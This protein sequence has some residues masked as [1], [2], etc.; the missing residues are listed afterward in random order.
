M[1]FAIVSPQ[2]PNKGGFPLAPPIL[3]YLGA[4]TLRHRPDAAVELIDANRRDMSPDD[5][6]ADLV[7]ISVITPSA[8]WSYSFADALRRRG[9]KVV[10][11][12]MHVTMLPDEAAAHADAVVLGEAESVWK[13]VLEDAAARRLAPRYVGKRLPLDGLPVPLR[14]RLSGRYPFR[15]VFTA[16]GCIQ[17]C[18]FCSVR[19]FFG[20]DVRLRPIGDVV[21]D[22]EEG[23]GRIYYNGDDNIWGPR[24]ERSI[25]LFRALSGGTRKWWFGQGDLVSVQQPGG[26]EMLRSAHRS[27]LRSVWVGFESQNWTTLRR[28]RAASKQGTDRDEAVKRI[29]GAGIEVVFF[30]ILGG[31]DDDLAEFDRAL[32]LSERL[33]VTIHPVLLTPYPG[34]SLYEEYRARL[35][36]LSWS[37]FDGVHAVFDHDDPQMTVDAREERLLQLNRELFSMRRV[38]RRTLAIDRKGFPVAHTVALMKQLAMR[39]GFARAYG[40]YLAQRAAER[41]G[42]APGA[43]PGRS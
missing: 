2:Y 37:K 15:A 21:R 18:A 27:G 29:A 28:Y 34:T 20:P 38:V 36:P 42:G 23:V 25:E 26:E 40:E 7:G 13:Q 11:G 1:R 5:V 17:R 31:A 12:G 16:R 19:A 33:G 22:V 8:D 14:G 9:V 4:L 39:R 32:E 35:R 30:L 43:N 41:R 10:L 6:D 3:E 24:I